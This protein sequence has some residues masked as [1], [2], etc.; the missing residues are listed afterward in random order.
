MR[1]QT[2]TVSADQLLDLA[3]KAEAQGDN[4]MAETAYRALVADPSVQVRSEA[5]FR[6]AMML[7]E[8]RRLTDAAILLRQILDEQPDAQRVRLELA[9]VLEMM[10]DEAGARRALR[11]AQAGGLPRDVARFVE[12]YSDALRAQKPVG[13]SLNLALA[14]DSNINSAS[15]SPTLQTVIGDFV[16]SEDARKK[17]GFGLWMNGQVYGRARLDEAVNLLGRVTGTGSLYGDGDYNDIALG[18]SGGPEIRAGADRISAEAAAVWRWY[19]GKPWSV[20]TSV[21]VNYF[22]PTDRQSQ[23]RAVGTIGQIDNKR[24][25]AQDGGLYALSLSYERA[26]SQRAGFSIKAT[27]DRRD[28]RDPG[29]ATLAGYGAL[30][31]YRE[32]GAATLIGTLTYGDLEAD[33]RMLIFP[34][35]RKD[36]FYQGTLTLNYR[37]LQVLGFAPFLRLT[38]E[39]NRSTVEIYDYRRLRTELGI[40]RAF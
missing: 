33:E 26:L 17:S 36:D 23:V 10:G 21:I 19:G 13:A 18:L 27:V 12:R 11:Q 39:R 1:S 37:R 35:K 9:R 34:R 16:L 32:I 5:R 15:G 4:A 28:L 8:R 31:A 29:L 2:A 24:S 14:P 22:H 38:A 40:D 7:V 3:E 20:T 30:T 25:A 6:L